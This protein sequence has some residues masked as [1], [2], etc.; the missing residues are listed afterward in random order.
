MIIPNFLKPGDKIALLAPA[1]FMDLEQ[2][3]PFESWII[4]NEWELVVSPNLGKRFHQFGGTEN[5]RLADI[6]WA[7]E[8][9]EIK[10]VFSARGGYGTL[11]LFRE[12]Q[13]LDFGKYPK[14]WVGFSD[15]TILHAVLNQKAL[16]SIHGPMAMQFAQQN[17]YLLNNQRSLE[18]ALN[19]KFQQIPFENVVCSSQQNA[20]FE[21]ILWGGNLSMIYTLAAAG[22]LPNLRGKVLF[23]EDIDE[24]TYHVDRML[25]ALEI[26]GLFEGIQGLIVGS[27]TDM[28]DHEI[29]FGWSVSQIIDD[30]LENYN[31]PIIKGVPCGHDQKNFSLKL[32]MSIKF[33]GETLFQF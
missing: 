7:L 29:P 11:R 33:D 6:I 1:R 32:G 30:V 15:L 3:Q 20:S 13:K 17:P 28:K 12:L 26:S 4:K 24:Y 31:F 10:A 14:W 16:S 18:D 8:N 21:G 9:T 22:E 27:M 19:G 23:I 5:E 25:R 2:L